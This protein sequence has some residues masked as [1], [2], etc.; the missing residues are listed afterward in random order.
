M[1]DPDDERPTVQADDWAAFAAGLGALGA[2]A[3]RATSSRS[4]P[5]IRDEGFR[6]L[7]QQT[8]CWLSWAIGHADPTA[9]S[10]QRQNDLVTHVGRSQRRQRVPARAR[11]PRLRRTASGAACTR[12][13][14]SSSA[15]RS[16]FR[17][18]DAPGDARRA[19]R[20]RHRHPRGRPTS[21]S[22]SAE[23]G[24]RA[25]PHGAARR[26]DHVLDP[27]VLLRLAARASPRTFTIEY[28]GGRA[29]AAA[30]DVR[31]RRSTRRSTSRERSIVFW[32]EYMDGGA[33]QAGRQHVRRQDRRAARAC[34]SSSSGSASTTSRPTRRCTCSTSTCPTRGTGACSSTSMAWFTPVDIGRTTSLNHAQMHVGAD[35]GRVHVVVAHDDPGVPNWLDTEGR[36]RGPGEPPALLGDALPTP[37]AEVVPVADVRDALPDGHAARRRRT[38][39]RRPAA[40]R[41]HLAWRFRT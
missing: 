3:S 21:S 35:D 41:D 32:N 30:A 40:R 16:G 9:P 1:T 22:C 31:R 29:G 15:I 8:L 13:R 6:H 4:T 20:V 17:H 34:S 25:E 10:F 14:T 2:P 27:R 19:H 28:L 5:S 38:A 11:R 24:R 36:A 26:R 33:R 7:A 18:T 23:T 12:A 39:C 37:D